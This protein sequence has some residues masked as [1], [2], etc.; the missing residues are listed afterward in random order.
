MRNDEWSVKWGIKLMMGVGSKHD[1][2]LV[3][4]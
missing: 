1:V 2:D 3:K 4:M